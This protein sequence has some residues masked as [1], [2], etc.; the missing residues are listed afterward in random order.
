MRQGGEGITRKQL[1]GACLYPSMTYYMSMV[2][3][4]EAPIFTKYVHDYLSEEEY[5]EFQH[6]DN[7]RGLDLSPKPPVCITFGYYRRKPLC[8]R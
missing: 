1:P 3:F 2:T 7:K 4:V 8:R 6:C 5:A